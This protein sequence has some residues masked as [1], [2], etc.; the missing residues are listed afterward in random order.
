MIQYIDVQLSIWGKWAVAQAQRSVGYPS[1]CP[2]FR[3]MKHGG[4]YGSTVPRG[5]SEY[6]CD[7]DAAVKRL[8]PDLQALAVEVYQRG[9]KMVEIAR[10]IDVPIRSFYAKLDTLHREVMGHLNDIAAGV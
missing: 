3:D 9:G 2:M 6:V 8:Q 4:V 1:I 7:T 5:V 10:R